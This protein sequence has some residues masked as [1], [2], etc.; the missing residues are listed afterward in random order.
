MIDIKKGRGRGRP[1]ALDEDQALDVAMAAFRQRGYDGVGIADLCKRL[2]VTPPSLYNMFGSKA[3]LYARV[4]ARYEAGSGGFAASAVEGAKTLDEAAHALLAAASNA[5]AANPNGAGCLVIEGT[6]NCSEEAAC[7]IGD[8]RRAATLAFLESVATDHE[9]GN[10]KSWG[11]HILTAMTG[12]SGAAR[13]GV[14]HADLSAIA[15]R[16]AAAAPR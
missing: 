13:H 16:F 8:E 15:A 10:P 5:Y 2:G 3:D 14:S 9:A 7:A 4:I 6:R 11:L 12:L 1:R